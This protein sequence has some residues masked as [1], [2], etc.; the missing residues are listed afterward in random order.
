MGFICGEG[1]ED[2]LDHV[3]AEQRVERL[4]ACARDGIIFLLHDFKGNEQ[5]VAAVDQLIPIL[6][7]KGF[8]FVTVRELFK[9]KGVKAQKNLIYSDV[10]HPEHR[11]Q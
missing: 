5:T 9:A 6:Q 11:I 10:M 3:T 1:C 2:W 8:R 7:A 4:T